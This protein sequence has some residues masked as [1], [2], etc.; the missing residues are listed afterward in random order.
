MLL[1]RHDIA[2]DHSGSGIAGQDF[3]E[4]E[5]GRQEG[6]EITAEERIEPTAF[7]GQIRL[8]GAHVVQRLIHNFGGEGIGRP[9]VEEPRHEQLQERRIGIV[10][11]MI[12]AR[13]RAPGLMHRQR[14]IGLGDKAQ[15]VG[16]ITV[17]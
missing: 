4:R 7:G 6:F 14:T 9:G 3:E 8:G 11:K 5:R 17:K 15:H 10:L 12:I 2:Q 16:R 13:E 1:P